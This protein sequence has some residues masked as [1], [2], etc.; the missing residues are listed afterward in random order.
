MLFINQDRT[1]TVMMLDPDYPHH[2]A[3]KFYLHLL[4]TNIPVSVFYR[5]FF[6]FRK[7]LVR[8]MSLNFVTKGEWLRQ[9]ITYDI[10]EYIVG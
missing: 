1:Y 2:A 9:G 7:T 6:Q 10:G 3:G 8:N 4:I 5:F